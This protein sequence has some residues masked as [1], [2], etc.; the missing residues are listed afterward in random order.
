VEKSRSVDRSSQKKRPGNEGWMVAW[1]SWWLRLKGKGTL[2][3]RDVAAARKS[4]LLLG[5]LSSGLYVFL[6]CYIKCNTYLVR[7]DWESRWVYLWLVIWSDFVYYC[8]DWLTSFGFF[9]INLIF[10][11]L[12]YKISLDNEALFIRWLGMD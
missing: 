10:S 9:K 2:I 11:L 3:C 1:I 6:L 7:F 4:G 12:F 5:V 8:S